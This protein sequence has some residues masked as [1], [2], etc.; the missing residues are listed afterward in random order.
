VRLSF[1]AG[2]ILVVASAIWSVPLIPLWLNAQRATLPFVA[3]G[4]SLLVVGGLVAGLTLSLTEHFRYSK[5]KKWLARHA[6]VD[7]LK[8]MPWDEFE[9]LVG[10]TFRQWGFRVQTQGGGHAD[11]GIDLIVHKRGKRYLVQCKRYKGSVGVP[12]IREMY[13]VMVAERFDGVYIMTSGKFTKDSW[14]FAKGKPMKLISGEA[15]ARILEEV[16][17]KL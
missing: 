2:L 16:T 13:G 6:R 17:A 14:A 8:A 12:V 9:R 4:H 1:Y 3:M 10:A 11:G 5:H 15:L 7:A